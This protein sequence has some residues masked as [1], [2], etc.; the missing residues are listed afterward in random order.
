MK[1]FL[2]VIFTVA[3]LTVIWLIFCNSMI[4]YEINHIYFLQNAMNHG[5]DT[6]PLASL[7]L[8]NSTLNDWFN[9]AFIFIVG[10]ISMI[11]SFISY[12]YFNHSFLTSNLVFIFSSLF[13]IILAIL[14]LI[15]TFPSLSANLNYFTIL[16]SGVLFLAI[17]NVIIKISKPTPKGTE[18]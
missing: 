1:S 16:I 6:D 15:F 11:S 7:E 13:S 8:F 12:R 2:I 5:K 4:V 18:G 17:T 10:L 3:L 9:Y 14:T